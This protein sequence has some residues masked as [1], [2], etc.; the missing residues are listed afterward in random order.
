[1]RCRFSSDL[2]PSH[3]VTRS[4]VVLRVA[5]DDPGSRRSVRS[6]ARSLHGYV[7]LQKVSRLVELANAELALL[8]APMTAARPSLPTFTRKNP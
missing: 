5:G 7:H 1:V 6:T 4:S 8:D 2:A 3:P